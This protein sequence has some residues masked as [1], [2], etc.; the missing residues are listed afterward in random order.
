ML[1]DWAGYY[2]RASLG[3]RWNGY[4][5][6]GEFHNWNRE[7]IHT[8][9]TNRY[10]QTPLRVKRLHLK[11]PCI[12]KGKAN[13][14]L[15]GVPAIITTPQF[16]PVVLPT[17]SSGVDAVVGKDRCLLAICWPNT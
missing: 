4:V 12:I 14:S 13:G 17:K 5:Q 3:H 9:S 2:K 16:P 11:S 6:T 8:T 7:K 1:V 10:N 15:A